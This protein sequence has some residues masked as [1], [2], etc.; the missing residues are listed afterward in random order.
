MARPLAGSLPDPRGVQS[1]HVRR[2]HA[3][4]ARPAAAGWWGP[5]GCRCRQ[6]G[7]TRRACGGAGGHAQAPGRPSSPVSKARCDGSAPDVFALDHPGAGSLRLRHRR[8]DPWVLTNPSA[9]SKSLMPTG[10]PG[11]TP[12]RLPVGGAKFVRAHPRV[13][14]GSALLTGWPRSRESA[15]LAVRRMQMTRHDHRQ[16]S[17]RLG[18]RHASSADRRAGRGNV[19]ETSAPKPPPRAPLLAHPVR[20]SRSLSQSDRL[21]ESPL[22]FLSRPRKMVIRVDQMRMERHHDRQR[23]DRL[24]LTFGELRVVDRVVAP[25]L[26]CLAWG[27]GCR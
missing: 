3:R 21:L 22:T 14:P 9:A 6:V 1:E 23:S 12:P 4:P 11:V 16:R 18:V 27:D 20:S 24:A 8:A 10:A 19:H 7:L 25:T 17:D 15:P 5:P 26:S 2:C 13:S